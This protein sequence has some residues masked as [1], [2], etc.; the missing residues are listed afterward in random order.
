MKTI[1]LAIGIT[2]AGNVIPNNFFNANDHKKDLVLIPSGTYKGATIQAFWMSNEI[3]NADYREFVNYV[4]HH[5]NDTLCWEDASAHIKCMKYSEI[6]GIAMVDTTV[7]Q[8]EFESN[9]EMKKKFKGYYNGVEFNNYPVVGVSYNQAVMYCAWRTFMD[10]KYSGK[11]PHGAAFRLPLMEEWLYVASKNGQQKVK[12]PDNMI[13]PAKSG[14]ANKLG[15]YNMDYNVSEWVSFVSRQQAV[16]LGDSWKSSTGNKTGT[17]LNPDA[18]KSD[19]G[20]RIVETYLGKG[21]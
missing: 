11:R 13:Q 10:T 17:W 15:V 1:L 14:V 19:I 7:L 6:A 21:K 8:R 3:T 4:E 20:F 5:P 9:K 2:L 18:Q 16:V 12:E